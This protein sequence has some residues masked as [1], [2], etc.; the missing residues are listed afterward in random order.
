MKRI[1]FAKNLEGLHYELSFEAKT[2]RKNKRLHKIKTYEN[3]C[4]LR[5]G[6]VFEAKSEFSKRSGAHQP[7]RFAL[8]KAESLAQE[9]HVC[10]SGST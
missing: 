6:S 3:N 2:H 1:L 4:P 9:A 10:A 7:P 5:T 8:R